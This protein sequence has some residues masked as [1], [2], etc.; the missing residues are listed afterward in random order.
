M[1]LNLEGLRIECA[2]RMYEKTIGAMPGQPTWFKLGKEQRM[3]FMRMTSECF[4]VLFSKDP[5]D[6]IEFFTGVEVTLEK[7]DGD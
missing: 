3:G 7:K 6:I 5:K 4:Q 2:R 1:A